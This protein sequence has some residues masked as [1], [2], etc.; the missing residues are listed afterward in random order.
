MNNC[1]KTK[2]IK[3]DNFE[4]NNEYIADQTS[5]MRVL[6]YIK[7]L[8]TGGGESL[9]FNIYKHID[10]KKIQF[11][12][13]VNTKKKERL[14]EQIMER[15]GGIYSIIN[16]EPKIIFFK[17]I[18]TSAGL[19]KLLASQHYDIIHIH[20]SNGQ[21]LYYS[22]LARQYGVK[23]VICHI[24]NTS[25]VGKFEK[26]KT[27]V[28]KY[29]RNKYMSAPTEYMACSMSAAKWLY[30]EEVIN[31][32]YF[33]ILKN[34]IDVDKFRFS[35]A[36]RDLIRDRIGFQNK[37]ILCTIGRCVKEK[38][39]IFVLKML[40]I[41]IK[42]DQD[43][44]LILIGQG[45]LED[46]LQNYAKSKEIDK[47]IA[48]IKSIDEVEKYLSASD[49]FILSSSS[50]EGLG[51]VAIEAQ[52]NGLRTIVSDNVPRDVLIT[53]YS[54]QLKLADGEQKWTSEILG[55]IGEKSV[56]IDRYEAGKYVKRAGYEIAEVSSELER[57]YLRLEH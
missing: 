10:R 19:R 12:F 41:L 37:K 55:M 50:S 49:F 20:C 27:I 1:N 54:Y 31:G 57:H 53:P 14:D 21:G 7:H 13:A 2:H 15:G 36:D 11:D 34:G 9:V 8:E 25:V 22:N 46:K 17:L 40:E 23:N 43:F 38:N 56:D 44:R 47:Y 33:K 51:I 28:H 6:H 18:A 35:E 48:F 39:Q 16:S 42:I 45:E 26:I 29:F 30:D 24:H 3:N 32:K 5:P 4:N 52:A